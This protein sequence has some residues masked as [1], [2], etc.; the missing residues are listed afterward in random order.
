MTL[1][2]HVPSGWTRIV[3]VQRAPWH[4]AARYWSIFFFFRKKNQTK[5]NKKNNKKFKLWT[6]T[7]DSLML[8]LLTHSQKDVI[9]KQNA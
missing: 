6:P 9:I 8:V 3:T 5:N 7:G 1:S 2:R 4:V